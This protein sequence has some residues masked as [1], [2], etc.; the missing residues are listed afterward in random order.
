MR[1]F[2]GPV[3]TVVFIEDTIKFRSGFIGPNSENRN[4]YIF[5]ITHMQK[6][7]TKF[8]FYD[9]D[10]HHSLHKTVLVGMVV[11]SHATKCNESWF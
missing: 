5:F 9:L 11:P 6:Q 8:H 7:L 2:G 10:H 4:I 1:I 3:H